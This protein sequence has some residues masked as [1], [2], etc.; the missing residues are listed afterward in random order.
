MSST[1]FS[2]TPGTPL[3][4]DP[5]AD[6]EDA[7][8]QNPVAPNATR[9][10]APAP[11]NPPGADLVQAEPRLRRMLDTA[12]DRSGGLRGIGGD[13]YEALKAEIPR[14]KLF[15]GGF[16]IHSAMLDAAKACDA[17]AAKLRGIPIGDFRGNPLPDAAFKAL[18]GFVD[19]QNKLYSQ[20]AAFQK[21]SGV[22]AALLDSLAQATQFRASEA[23]DKLKKK[24]AVLPHADAAGLKELAVAL[25][26][27]CADASGIEAAFE[28][29]AALVIVEGAD[30]LAPALEAADR[31]T[32]VVVASAS[33]TAFYGLAVN[34]KAGTVGRAVNAQDIAVTIATIADIPVDES[35]T[36]AIIYQV[37]KNPN[38]KLEEIKKLK[39]ALVRMES[40]IQRDNREPWDKHD[41]A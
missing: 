34:A 22:R 27:V 18:K 20:I 9:D 11:G 39:E 26:G 30:A 15:H 13:L 1:I 31:R 2:T 38:L 33:G 8:R 40:V 29:D 7:G 14:P 41:C 35:C 19:A 21:A 3:G 10:E 6:V 37:M 17:A 32:L 12:L 4:I 16:S 5:H 23:L 24:A 28:A 36:G 25:G